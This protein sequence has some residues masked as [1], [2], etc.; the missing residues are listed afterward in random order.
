MTRD[1]L[2]AVLSAAAGFAEKASVFR[3]TGDH[4]V[5]LYLGSDSRGMVVQ[6]VTEVALHDRFV[7]ATAEGTGT[8]YADY[9]SV[10]ALAVKPPKE[11]APKKAGFA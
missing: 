2:Q 8:V 5:T 7:A 4:R 10:F 11:Y 9:D 6:E 1:V 3:T